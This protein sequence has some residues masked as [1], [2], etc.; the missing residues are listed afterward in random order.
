MKGIVNI[1]GYRYF[2]NAVF[3]DGRAK[4]L[5]KYG[6]KNTTKEAPKGREERLTP[7]E[8][9]E[10][11]IMKARKKKEGRLERA[12]KGTRSITTFCS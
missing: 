10:E 6:L 2:D 11:K 5:E 7:K 8:R 1:G 4:T 12:A 9:Q 3:Y